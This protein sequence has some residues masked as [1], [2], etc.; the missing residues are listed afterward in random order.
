MGDRRGRDDPP[1]SSANS[2]PRD[3]GRKMCSDV[4]CKLIGRE[5]ERERESVFKCVCVCVC[6]CVC[7]V[8]SA[9]PY[10]GGGGS[11]QG[12]VS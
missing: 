9:F 12:P 2:K 4:R 10:L 8:H 3:V 7:D 6:V 5:K 1:R 11:G